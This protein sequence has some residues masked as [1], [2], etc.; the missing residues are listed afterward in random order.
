METRFWCWESHSDSMHHNARTWQLLRE[1]Q[2]L[3][4]LHRNF[5]VFRLLAGHT[6]SRT[7]PAA[8]TPPR[9]SCGEA[10]PAS[11]P[12]S[13]ALRLS[14]PSVYTR[15]GSQ[16]WCFR[17][18]TGGQGMVLGWGF[19]TRHLPGSPRKT[20]GSQR[21]RHEWVTQSSGWA[22]GARGRGQ[23]AIGDG[24]SAEPGPPVPA[25]HNL[26]LINELRYLAGCGAEAAVP[27]G[28]PGLIIM[29]ILT[30]Y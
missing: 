1:L 28:R 29:R 6:T 4:K 15:F 27:A 22:T 30:G 19:P 5:L 10:A 25:Q 16:Y 20:R 9:Q 2:A 13:Q 21:A 26:L 18:T 11:L 17:D 7:T 3:N 12:L 8:C 24:P 14:C 23:R